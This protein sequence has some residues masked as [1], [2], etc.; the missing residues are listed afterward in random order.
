MKI[1]KHVVKSILKA[2]PS[3]TPMT[4]HTPSAIEYAL[5]KVSSSLFPAF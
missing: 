1:V 4:S 5:Q 2:M 3:S